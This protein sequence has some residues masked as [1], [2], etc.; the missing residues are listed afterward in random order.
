GLPWDDAVLDF[1]LHAKQRKTLATPSYGGV[2]QKIYTDSVGRWR[3]YAPWLEPV[4]PQFKA[5]AERY[6]YDLS[7]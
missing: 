5:T 4:L 7:V 3:H 6:G 2:T 1:D